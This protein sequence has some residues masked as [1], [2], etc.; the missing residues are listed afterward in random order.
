MRYQ[1]PGQVRDDR[2]L[3]RDRVRVASAVLRGPGSRCRAA[4]P[5]RP[6]VRAGCRE[7]SSDARSTW[8]G[9]TSPTVEWLLSYSRWTQV[10]LALSETFGGPSVGSAG[11]AV[12]ARGGS[13]GA[14]S[15]QPKE[16][17]APAAARL[18]EERP[19]LRSLRPT[20]VPGVHDVPVPGAEWSTIR[21]PRA[22]LLGAVAVDRSHRR[23]A[24]QH[25]STVEVP[26]S[27]RVLCTMARLRGSAEHRIDYPPHSSEAWSESRGAFGRSLP[28]GVVPV[29]RVPG[30]V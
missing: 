30:G 23:G 18:S 12:D 19:Y 26:Y 21:G 28:G 24:R 27:S 8:T 16:R 14:S 7:V 2:E 25:P 9:T 3:H 17:N 13:D 10:E 20:R 11:R 29:A 6:G 4:D 22:G 15:R 1:T 5:G